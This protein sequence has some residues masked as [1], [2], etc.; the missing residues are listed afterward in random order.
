MQIRSTLTQDQKDSIVKK[1]TLKLVG[2]DYDIPFPS[3]ISS[4]S[5]IVT[6][7]MKEQTQKFYLIILLH[8]YKDLFKVNVQDFYLMRMNREPS[9]KELAN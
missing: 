7:P 4:P 1:H 6:T 3:A 9:I 8:G 2:I 5:K